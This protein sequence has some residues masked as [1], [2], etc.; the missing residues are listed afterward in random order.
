MTWLDIITLQNHQPLQDLAARG[1]RP[2]GG[3]EYAWFL[4]RLVSFGTPRRLRRRCTRSRSSRD[5]IVIRLGPRWWWSRRRARRRKSSARVAAAAG[6]RNGECKLLFGASGDWGG[7]RLAWPPDRVVGR[8]T[9]AATTVGFEVGELVFEW[10]VAGGG[11]AGRCA[12]LGARILK[13]LAETK[14]KRT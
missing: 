8:R 11:L 5:A 10:V 14:Q 9:A 2:F 4:F 3:Q 1:T 12:W 13:W 7:E 6:A